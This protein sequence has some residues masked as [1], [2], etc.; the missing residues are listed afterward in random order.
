[1]TAASNPVGPLRVVAAVLAASIAAVAG[2]APP[3]S[4]EPT[5]WRWWEGAA[6]QI[7]HGLRDH[8][9]LDRDD[10]RPAPDHPEPIVLV[11]GTGL[12]GGNS[13]AALGSELVAAGY[14]VWAPT[15]GAQPGLGFAGGLDSLTGASAPQLATEID[16][17][18]ALTGAPTVALVGHSQGAV[19]AAYVAKV[20]RPLQVSRVVTLG[21]DPGRFGQG[22]PPQVTDAL[23]V[24]SSEAA[25]RDA[26]ATRAWLAGD[27]LPYARGVSYTAVLSDADELTGPVPGVAVPGGVDL[28]VR[29]LQDG[30][31]VDRSGHL[32]VLTSPRAIDLVRDALDP[33]REVPLRCVAADGVWGVREPVPAAR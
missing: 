18:T 33:Q 9:S 3:V 8:P 15:V 21:V 24:L 4:A 2:G 26:D 20:H 10:C 23:A 11:H 19:L 5:P 1:M 6:Y 14:C 30:C 27:G 29:R 22:P 32:T 13:W 12:N 31:E 17:V 25:A 16:R 28:R 7:A